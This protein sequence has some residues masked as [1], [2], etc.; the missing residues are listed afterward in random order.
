MKCV[1]C[2]AGSATCDAWDDGKL[3]D[4]GEGDENDYGRLNGYGPHSNHE[5]FGYGY[6]YGG[7][8]H[9]LEAGGDG[10]NPKVYSG[11]VS[12]CILCKA[13]QFAPVAGS[14]CIECPVGTY[15]DTPGATVCLN[16]PA[17]SAS[18]KGATASTDCIACSPGQFNIAGR[19]VY[20]DCVVF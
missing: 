2:A 19:N 15:V 9:P 17:G 12:D 18:K 5:D 16:C 6:G 1:A 7:S 11:E 8:C 10:A 3:G 13:G 14:A 4:P 20:S